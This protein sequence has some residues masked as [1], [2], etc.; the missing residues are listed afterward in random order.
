MTKPSE[1][2]V[3]KTSFLSS[4]Y[5]RFLHFAARLD[6]P[7]LLVVRVIWGWQYTID[8]WGKL[9]NLGH[10]VG[11]FSTL[12]IPF[13][14][15]TAVLV[16]GLE[17]VGGILLIAGLGTRLVGLLLAINMLAAYFTV[18]DDRAAFLTL[19]SNDPSSFVKADPFP[20]LCA[21]V[22]AL[23]FGAG[24]VSLDYWLATR[25]KS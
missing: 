19:F 11:F 10:V 17:F 5:C 24:T 18:A 16:S 8:G 4:A 1:V 14:G 12:P 7:F 15:A 6:T 3:S 21:A 13:P 9:H 23:V 25:K 20:Y 2:T 22:V